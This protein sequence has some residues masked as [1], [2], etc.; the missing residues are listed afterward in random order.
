[1]LRIGPVEFKTTIGTSLRFLKQNSDNATGPG[2]NQTGPER[3]Q[4]LAFRKPTIGRNLC[5]PD[6]ARICVAASEKHT[7]SAGW[8]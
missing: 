7:D 3:S 2:P 1:M 8:Q 4:G 5:A 6:S